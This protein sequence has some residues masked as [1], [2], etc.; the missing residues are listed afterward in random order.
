MSAT[1]SDPVYQEAYRRL[2]TDRDDP[3]GAHARAVFKERGINMYTGKSRQPPG[4]PLMIGDREWLRMEGQ[5]DAVDSSPA[6]SVHP[7]AHNQGVAAPTAQVRAL[8]LQPRADRDFVAVANQYID[9]VLT[10]KVPACLYVRNACQRQRDDLVRLADHPIFY[11]DRDAA[12]RVCIFI[13]RMPHVKGPKASANEDITLEPWQCFVLTTVFGWKRKDTGGRR[14]RRSYVEVPRGNGKSALSSAVGLYGMAYDGEYGAEVYCLDPTTRVLCGD[15]NWRRIGDLSLGDSLIAFDEDAPGHKKYR[16]LRSARV[17]STTRIMQP[18]CEVTMKDGRKIIASMTHK[19]LAQTSIS[20]NRRSWIETCELRPGAL[21]RDLGQPWEV[22]GSWESGY[23]AGVFDGEACFHALQ[24]NDDGAPARG[25]GFRI[26][27]AQKPGVVL[28]LT[29]Q[30]CIAKG[31]KVTGLIENRASGV[32][33]FSISGFYS[34][35][36]F[37]GE[38][39]PVR[40]L[41]NALSW[42]DGRTPNKAGKCSEVVS[43]KFIG[44]REVVAM[45]T[46]TKTLFAEG[47]FSHNS[48]ATTRDQARIVFGDAQTMMRKRGNM[49]DA[50]RVVVS[51][52]PHGALLLQPETNSKFEPLSREAGTMDGKNVHVA[53]IDELH[54]H[55][56]RDVMD[57]IET[58]TA[59]RFSSLI[60]IITTAGSDTSGICYE[61]RS[62]VVKLL[63]KHAED[64]SQFGIIY[65][66]DEGDDWRDPEVWRKANP[67][68]GVSVMPDAFASLA[69]KA[70]QTPAAQNNFKTKYLDQW[71]SADMAWM[72]LAAWDACSDPSLDETQF[73]GEPCVIGLDL[74][75]KVDIACK[76]KLFR[77]ER[78]GKCH[79]Y[80]FCESYLPEQAITDGR[81]ASY[82]GWDLEQRIITTPG[83]VLDFA[84]IKEGLLAD[85][86]AYQITHCGYDPWQA[87]QL[88]QEMIAEAIQMVEVRATVNNF[89]A[90][91]KE[92]DALVRGGL[93]H[94]DGNPVMRWMISNVVAHTDAKENIYPRKERRENKIDGVVATI[95]ALHLAMV[96][97]E[98]EMDSGGYTAESGLRAL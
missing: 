94:H 49:R 42:C 52:S 76:V 39:R 93:L 24:R 26:S 15:F 68:W 50:L 21:I 62:Y 10:G 86:N 35:A 36:K 25:D 69:T 44:E 8:S 75:S 48:A 45:G 17:I 54:A 47:L 82:A 30:L 38:N 22:S 12:Q 23:L 13:E 41:R 83:D 67:N 46:S 2:R 59:K 96:G 3:L 56:T 9:D 28:D 4:R 37:L 88:A 1:A 87:T 43:V 72:D 79:Y 97:G 85:R 16:K 29:Y 18:C 78:D 53:V 32:S 31:Y 73:R 20:A 40:L 71:V 70:M 65:T 63:E 14:F 92:L 6:V 90:P 74:T 57:V 64:D 77:R 7:T 61:V 66:T 98:V 91:M 11:F 33:G 80:L 27:F 81:N 5:I 60:W 19:W 51:T 34:C 55:K 89:S 95:M 84:V 58:A